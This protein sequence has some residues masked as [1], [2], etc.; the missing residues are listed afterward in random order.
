[1]AD[2][3]G[4]LPPFTIELD[5]ARRFLEPTRSPALPSADR[6]F[7]LE[8]HEEL[9]S[10]VPA[11][12]TPHWPLHGTPH[13]GNWLTTPQGPLLLDF[14]TACQGP[15]E[16]DLA[17]LSDEAIALFPDVDYELIQLLRRMRSL[18]VAAKCWIEPRRAPE[19]FEAAHVHLRLLRG[20]PLE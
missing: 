1:L 7:L 9:R 18:C 17:A 13:E 20:E 4:S 14:E 11:L 5:D 2:F 10:A 6:A 3:P 16:W 12:R 19:V 8:V 15:F